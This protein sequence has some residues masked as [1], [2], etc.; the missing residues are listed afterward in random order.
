MKAIMLAA[1]KGTRISRNIADIPKSVLPIGEK[2]L[3]RLSAEMLLAKNIQPVVC[4]GYRQDV[5][6]EVL[7]GLDVIFHYNPFYDVTNS[8]ASLWFARH[9]LTTDAVVMNADVFFSP[10]ILELLLSDER[11]ATMLA[12]HSRADVGDYF[13]HVEHGVITR[14]GKDLS[15]E[16]RNCE[17]VGMARISESFMD[18]FLARMI[19]MIHSQ[20]HGLWWENILYSFVSE[21]NIHAIDVAGRFW[22]EIDY[23]EDYERILDYIAAQ[24]TSQTGA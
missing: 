22:S 10:D 18:I 6:R 24:G 5:I 19:S 23:V 13:F 7:K 20:Q 12:D 4:V 11:P 16:D 3:I 9:E 15:R 14:Y 2:P 17:Y 1:G 8:I 21:T